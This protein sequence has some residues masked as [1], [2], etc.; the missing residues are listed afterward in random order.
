MAAITAADIREYLDAQQATPTNVPSALLEKIAERAQDMVYS[1]LG[2][3]FAAYGAT[4]TTKNVFGSGS[5]IL[6]LPAHEAGSV[7]TVTPYGSSSA[8]TGWIEQADGSLYLTGHNPRAIGGWVE[9]YNYTVTAKWGYGPVPDDVTQV[10]LEIAVNIFRGRGKGMFESAI[11]ETG[12]G[13]IR[14]IGGV[15]SQQRA[16]LNAVRRKYFP[17]RVA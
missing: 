15:T 1:A 2:F 12:A 6:Y 4:T 5:P 3:E 13:Q 9:N 16:V 7:T 11:G 10:M 17:L 14:F 8:I